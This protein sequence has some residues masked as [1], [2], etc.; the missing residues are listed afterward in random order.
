M[1]LSFSIFSSIFGGIVCCKGAKPI[2]RFS[3][4]GN[5]EESASNKILSNSSNDIGFSFDEDYLL[6]SHKSTK[7]LYDNDN[8]GKFVT[9]A[10]GLVLYASHNVCS[11]IGKDFSKIKFGFLMTNLLKEDFLP[12][13]QSWINDLENQSNHV[14][15]HRYYVDGHIV[16]ILIEAYPI[17]TRGIFK[18]MKGI[19]LH[20]PYK[21]WNKFKFNEQNINKIHMDKAH[22]IQF[23]ISI[24]L[25]HSDKTTKQ[26]Y[27]KKITHMIEND[28]ILKK[29][30]NEINDNDQFDIDFAYNSTQLI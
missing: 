3:C 7:D 12:V 29:S 2:I 18:G 4:C 17:Y 9:D 11:F 10:D 21:I 23:P 27:Y 6:K 14:G 8:V 13:F 5:V 16:Y 1:G 20:V 25:I 26:P 22:T 24:K 19:M 28:T 15:K 30:T